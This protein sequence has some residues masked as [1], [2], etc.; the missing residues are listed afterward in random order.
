LCECL[1]IGNA[2]GEGNFLYLLHSIAEKCIKLYPLYFD[3]NME[4]R[5]TLNLVKPNTQGLKR[6]KRLIQEIQGTLNK[7][8]LLD[9]SLLIEFR[10]G[11]L[12]FS[13]LAGNRT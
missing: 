13:I 2:V 8:L 11:N 9:D 1:A 3:M 7:F 4:C 5:G 6:H 12:E 10:K